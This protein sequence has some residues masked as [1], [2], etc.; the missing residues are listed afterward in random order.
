MFKKI[1]CGVI[2]ATLLL[3]PQLVW[4]GSDL[5]EV[6]LIW[7]YPGPYPQQD[8]DMVYEEINKILKEKINATVDFRA[9]NWG[10]YE[11]RI[12]LV[13]ASGENYDLC[14]TA[15]W[16]NNYLQNVS[17]GA[18]LPLDDLIDEYAPGLKALV[19]TAMWDATRVQGKIYGL[20]NYQI[21][22]M[23]NGAYFK[24]ELVDKY[25]FDVTTVKEM[26]D[27]EPFLA[28]IKEYDP[29]IYP[30]GIVSSGGGNWAGWITHFG[31]DEVV[32]RDLPGAVY[33]DDIGAIPTAI[34]QYKTD[35][36]KKF[37][38]TVAEWFQ[39]GYVRSDALA[40]TDAQPMTKAGLMGVWFGG[41]VKP[42]GDAEHLA[43]HGY[44]MIQHP[45]SDPILK[46]SSIISTMHGINRNS[47]NPERAMM[48]MEL[49][50]TDVE[51]YNLLCFGIEGV[52]YNKVGENQIELVEGSGY[53]PNTAW[54]FGCQ[55]NAY[56]LPGQADTL[57]EE[58]HALNMSAKPSPLLGF[59]FDPVPI[60]TEIA[61]C[62]AV[63]DEYMR[64]LDTGSSG[65]D[66]EATLAEFTAKLDE[67][68]AERI[69]S[70]I[71]TQLKLWKLLE[72]L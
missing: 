59:A 28:L 72:L 18:F 5:E 37:A 34:N 21:S 25:G 20:I 55:F 17:K 32:G 19:P 33:I 63:C 30:T 29:D 1:L 10:D 69:I 7:Y 71:N 53:V 42:G 2:M 67:A 15:N 64:T 38:G 22:C 62:Q 50:N 46:T 52:H 58:T 48:F 41:N 26:E 66:W 11:D 54:L 65:A 40:I 36:F 23:T 47:K 12:R 39:K 70:E 56:F 13:I 9:Q 16:F 57:W 31:F 14:F 43:A 44:E 27:L 61:Q 24:K 8:A 6:E 3:A 45:I 68:G 60:K 51:L 35:E 4:A 49:L